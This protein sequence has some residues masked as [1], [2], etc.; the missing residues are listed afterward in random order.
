MRFSWVFNAYFWLIIK[1]LVK[2]I[3]IIWFSISELE[4]LFYFS[5]IALCVAFRVFGMFHLKKLIMPAEKS[6]ELQQY[7]RKYWSP[8]PR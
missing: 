4:I 6:Q 8:F 2:Y 3:G 5:A 1:N 7:T